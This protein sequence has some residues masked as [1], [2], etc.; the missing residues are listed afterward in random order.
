LFLNSYFGVGVTAVSLV[1]PNEMRAQA[2][3]VLFFFCNLFGLAFGPT[4]VAILTDFIFGSDGALNLSLGFLPA[5]VLP[6]SLVL[7]YLA[8]RPYRE[9]IQSRTAEL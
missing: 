3:A 6:P 4:A 7:A 2:T 1:T 5:I 8:L 9:L